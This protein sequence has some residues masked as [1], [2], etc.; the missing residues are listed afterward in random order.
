[1]HHALSRVQAILGHRGV[2]TAEVTG[3][4]LLG[5]RQHLVPW[6]DRVVTTAVRDRPWPG[7]LEPPLPTTLAP[8]DELDVLT[9][10]GE[11]VHVTERGDTAGTP[12]YFVV[13]RQRLRISSWAGPWPIA[14]RFWLNQQPRYRFQVVD[15]QSRAWVVLYEND[16]WQAEGRYD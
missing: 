7:H 9:A 8:H 14:E 11:R 3:G 15:E 2:V 13:G 16:E 1:M 5:D 6:G 10:M 12:E 4:R